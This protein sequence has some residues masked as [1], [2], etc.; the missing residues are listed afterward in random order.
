[1]KNNLL[2]GLVATTALSLILSACGGGGGSVA[3]TA[4]V[5]LNGG[6]TGNTGSSTGST[7]ST[8]GTVVNT[9]GAGLTAQDINTFLNSSEYNRMAAGGY[10]GL[11]QV[12]AAQ[13]YATGVSGSGITVAVID[14]GIDLTN[15]EFAGAISADSINITNGSH[16]DMASINPH[17]TWVSGVVGARR[18]GDNTQGV[19]F[20]STI[21]AVRADTVDSICPSGCFIAQD[22]ASSIRYATDHNARVIN[23]SMGAAGS[24]GGLVQSAATYAAAHN[25]LL[26]AAA[27][28]EGN[29]EIDAPAN[30]GGTAGVVGSM[31][32]VGAVDQNNVITSWSNKAGAA[33]DYY[34]V[35]P[36]EHILTTDVGGGMALTA[37]TSF[38]SPMVAGAAALV[39]QYAPYLTAQQVASIL[40]NSATDLGAAGVDTVYG[41]GLLNI[42]AALGPAGTTS[43]PTATGTSTPAVA[44]SVAMSAAFGN[45]LS[46]NSLLQRG[47][48]L[49]SYG[50]A[51]G[52]DMSKRVAAT[53]YDS[54]L[55]SFIGATRTTT[56]GGAM[57]LGT[58]N[59]S[60]GFA[61]TDT[62]HM[63]QDL[64]KQD[65]TQQ[66]RGQLAL[67]T[68][69]ASGV[70]LTYTHNH[71][72][73]QMFGLSE[74]A[75]RVANDTMGTGTL[76]NAF[77]GLID[78]GNALGTS[79]DLGHGLALNI[80]GGMQS[81]SMSINDADKTGTSRQ[82][83]VA[84]LA[85]KADGLKLGVQTGMVN[86][87]GSTLASNGD[88]ALAFGSDSRTT[89]VGLN[90]T[91]PL[92]QGLAL[93]ATYQMGFTQITSS[94]GSLISDFRGV[95][96][97]KFAVALMAD[98]VAKKG[99]RLT[100]SVSQPIRV[101]SGNAD[102]TVPVGVDHNG[103][104]IN[105][106]Q[107]VGL[108]P[109]G[110]QI[111][112]GIGYA[113][114]LG[115]EQQLGISTVSTLNPG[116]NADAGAA[117]AVGVRYS[118]QF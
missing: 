59:V 83:Y 73:G 14:T 70:T 89:F 82:G 72:L 34:L 116:Q 104:V 105:A 101:S 103:S 40:L 21:L 92:M 106:S 33:K 53:K 96:S 27:G 2:N 13:A 63:V 31:L 39:M 71:N 99:D 80:G 24:L 28:N 79:F 29:A 4:P 98:D 38:A 48:M 17:G 25:V 43:V 97:D 76:D 74:Q 8:G 35:A 85:Y 100:L 18:D 77:L 86:E 41:H 56:S 75:G 32:A 50:R 19:A 81:D 49:D 110:R 5:N 36:G 51:Y 111:D 87:S 117:F 3:T 61:S 22:V 90:A 16:T 26:V 46:N 66:S 44:S 23:M 37:G 47:I 78:G 12:N 11:A 52:F 102:L 30:L 84:E 10:T 94:Q 91:V 7:G 6:S 112:M 107:R 108:T 54:G 60:F 20:N 95:S 57:Q 113:F 55:A 58:S 45:A 115:K 9:P 109:T 114:N 1:M 65:K 118:A 88:G 62:E 15:S 93:G 68:Q 42:G 69:A 64:N 67:T